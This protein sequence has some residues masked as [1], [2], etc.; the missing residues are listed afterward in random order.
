MT[1]GVRG[2]IVGELSR[3]KQTYSRDTRGNK[4]EVREACW[5]V[6]AGRDEEAES[7]EDKHS[8]KKLGRRGK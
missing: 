8:R 1:I 2:M 5:R 4:G 6:P 7:T 3:G